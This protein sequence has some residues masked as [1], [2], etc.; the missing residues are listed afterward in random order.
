MEPR[1]FAGEIVY[2][3]P[4]R[5][6]HKGA[7]I[8]LQV[9]SEDGDLHAYIKRYVCMSGDYVVVTQYNPAQE[10]RFDRGAVEAMHL[11]VKSGIR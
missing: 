11:I 10:I 8:V 1:Y 7:H 2:V 3:H 5:A 9:R 4:T 6:I